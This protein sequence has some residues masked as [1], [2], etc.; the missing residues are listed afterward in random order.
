MNL[1]VTRICMFRRRCASSK[2]EV[3][4]IDFG[5]PRPEFD[6]YFNISTVRLA[7]T[8]YAKAVPRRH[9]RRRRCLF[10]SE[11]MPTASTRDAPR[12]DMWRT[13]SKFRFEKKIYE[14]SDGAAVYNAVRETPSAVPGDS[15]Q[16]ER[17]AQLLQLYCRSILLRAASRGALNSDRDIPGLQF[18]LWNSYSSL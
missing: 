14:R 5:A 9:Q 16:N 6:E 12:T 17:S 7:G 2:N 11:F 15:T 18:Y 4:R 3:G 13:S 10:G 1:P 8:L